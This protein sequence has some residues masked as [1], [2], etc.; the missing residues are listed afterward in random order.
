MKPVSGTH[1]GIGE[2]TQVGL[3]RLQK[4]AIR[5]GPLIFFDKRWIRPIPR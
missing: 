3:C 5:I 1:V 4:D 2:G